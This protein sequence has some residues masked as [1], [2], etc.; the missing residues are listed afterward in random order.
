MNDDFVSVPVCCA[1]VN[2]C[3]L[4]V[5]GENVKTTIVGMC[6]YLLIMCVSHRMRDEGAFVCVC[7]L[8]H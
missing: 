7:S 2:S 4:V 1:Q 3:K 8:S 6:V 5:K